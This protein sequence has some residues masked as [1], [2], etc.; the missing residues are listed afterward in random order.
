M[1]KRLAGWG[2]TAYYTVLIGLMVMLFTIF[3]RLTSPS[4]EPKEVS[5]P[6]EFHGEAL[7][8]EEEGINV[9]SLDR[10]TIE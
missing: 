7:T 5:Q 9:L 8:F 2:L 10:V 4:E 1:N 3:Y 6:T